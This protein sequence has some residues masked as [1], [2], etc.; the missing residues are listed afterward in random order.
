MQLRTNCHKKSAIRVSINLF[1][2]GQKYTDARTHYLRISLVNF[3]FFKEKIIRQSL[4]KRE[5]TKHINNFKISDQ[6]LLKV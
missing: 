1:G 2:Y 3:S 5:L 4:D 6:T